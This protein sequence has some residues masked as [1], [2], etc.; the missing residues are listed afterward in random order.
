MVLLVQSRLEFV[1]VSQN[2]R[3]RNSH[4]LLPD[5]HPCLTTCR[6]VDILG[7]ELWIANHFS[8]YQ[9][10]RDVIYKA[11]EGPPLVLSTC[12]LWILLDMGKDKRGKDDA[13]E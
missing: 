2:D 9:D 11:V 6:T 7:Y 3:L 10:A 13:C 1:V 5:L 4:H 8:T 12:E